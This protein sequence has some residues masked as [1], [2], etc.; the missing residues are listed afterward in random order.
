[1]WPEEE[2]LAHHLIKL[3]EFAFAWTEEEK[4][5]FLSDY[6]DP[7]VIPI[8]E[9]ILWNLKYIPIPPGI[10][11]R[12][13][14]IIKSKIT[15]GVYEPSNSS[16]RSRWFC[17]LKKDGKSLY[18]VYDLQPLN[19]IVVKDAGLPPMVEQYAKLFGARGCYGIFDLMVGFDQRALAPQSQ[20]LTT[21]QSSLGT[22][23][24]TSIPMGYT[25]SMQIQHG[26]LTFLL[27]NEIPDIAVP[28]I[29]DVPVK[30]PPIRYEIGPNL[31]ETL[32]KNPGIHRFIWEHFVKVDQILQRV[33]HA[34]GTFSAAKSHISVP[35]AVVVG[36]LCT[37]EGHLPDMAYVQKIVDWPI[38]QSLIEV[39][40]FLGTIGTI[41]IFIKNYV[42]IAHPLVCLTRKDVEFTFGK[43]EL[44]AMKKLKVLVKNSSAIC[45]INYASGNKVILA[46][47]T[48]S[49]AIGYI[50]SQMGA[51]A[52]RYPS[53]FGSMTL[54]E[55]ESRYSQAKLELFGLFHALKDCRIWIIGVKNLVV[56]VD[57][58]YIKGMINNPDIQ[59]N[60]TINYWISAI[61]L[62]D[63]Q[64]CHVPGHSHGPDGLSRCP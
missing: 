62:F 2:K 29:D 46:V 50:L 52:K 33:Q 26:D 10:F 1:L 55:R 6:F 47:D 58:K 44:E 45:A 40:G 31:F 42:T 24:L 22:L 60:A 16:Y 57:T 51:N 7:V 35:S 18:L 12:V 13:V 54:S 3:Q 9:H 56:E 53:R 64:L 39:W 15:A 25:N 43:Q 11:P 30:G 59:P 14:E 27:Q 38:C 41:R 20:D 4:G 28:F 37:Y 61:L 49:I 8:V 36:H 34:G 23:R 19:A 21:F 63:F 48:S 5:K 32:P 17:V